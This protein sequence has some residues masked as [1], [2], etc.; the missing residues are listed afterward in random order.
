MDNPAGTPTTVTQEAP[1]VAPPPAAAPA[2]EVS[3]K[4]NLAPDYANSPTMKKFADTKEGLNQAVQSHLSLEKLLGHEKVP[5]PKGKDD[6]EGW[7]IFSKAMGVPE[8]AEGYALDDPKIPDSMKNFTFDKGKFA[9]I[10]HAHKLTPEAAKGLW[11]AYTEMTQ[12]IYSKAVKEQQETLTNTINQLRGEWGDAFQTKVDLGQMVINKF[13]VNKDM[14]DYVTAVMT[15]DAQGIKFLATLGEQFKENKIS[16]F[17]NV[18]YSMTPDEAQKEI[19]SI[20]QNPNHPY[21]NDKAP[22]GERQKAIDYVNGLMSIV[23]KRPK[24]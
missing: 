15:K 21:V 22:D 3:W 12:G 17:Q 7:S 2:A 20:R 14:A 18:G 11:G 16:G 13:S 24:G 1:P 19:D 8:T 9:E 6:V 10:V 23:N 5:I 4:A